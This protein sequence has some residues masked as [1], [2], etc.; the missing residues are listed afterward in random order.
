MKRFMNKKV[1]VIAVVLALMFAGAGVVYGFFTSNGTGKG[2]ATVGTASPWTVA[3]PTY[4]GAMLPGSGTSVVHFVVTN[5]GAE[6]KAMTSV[7]AAI[8]ASGNNIVEGPTDVPVLGCLAEWFTPVAGTPVPALNTSIASG[9]TATEDVT[10]SMTDAATNQD[11]CQGK[12]PN[13]EL[14]VG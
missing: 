13:V 8:K 11:A 9:G 1:A 7:T 6:A 10:V 12:T 4:T 14:T 3:G 5:D 2:E